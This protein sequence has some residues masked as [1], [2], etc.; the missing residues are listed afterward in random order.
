[1]IENDVWGQDE[2]NAPWQRSPACVGGEEKIKRKNTFFVIFARFSGGWQGVSKDS[3][4]VP[5]G[6]K[7]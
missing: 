7:R 1:M 5:N 4:D 3:N 2:E 6:C